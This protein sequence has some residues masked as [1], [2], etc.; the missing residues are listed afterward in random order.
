[1]LFRSSGYG[2]F[3][4]ASQTVVS[5]RNRVALRALSAEEGEGK[6]IRPYLWFNRTDW[7]DDPSANFIVVNLRQPSMYMSAETVRNFFG[8]PIREKRFDDYLILEYSKGLNR[9]FPR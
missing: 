1:M 8:S 3:W 7:Y 4:T 6:T 9:R 5:S 2:D